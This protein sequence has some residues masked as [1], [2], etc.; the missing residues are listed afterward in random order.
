MSETND[1]FC[2]RV[3]SL[4]HREVLNLDHQAEMKQ[5]KNHA[6]ETSAKN[7]VVPVATSDVK[8]FLKAYSE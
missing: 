1:K 8:L 2:W 3:P 7:G 6:M 5:N 4:R